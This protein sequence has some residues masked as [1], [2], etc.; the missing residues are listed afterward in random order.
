LSEI[1]PRV[2]ERIRLPLWGQVVKVEGSVP[3]ALVDGLGDPVEPVQV[4][5]RDFTARGKSPGSVRSYAMDLL[6]WWRFLIAIGVAWDQVSS[7]DVRDFVLWLT[8]AT[9]SLAAQR[10]QSARTVGTINPITRK[11][12]LDDHYKPATIRHSNAVLRAFY[13]FWIERGEGPMFNPVVRELGRNGAR[14]NAHHNP[15]QPFRAEGRL[16]YNPRLPKRRPRMMPDEEWGRFF[17]V[18]ASNRDR[19]LMAVD[20]SA[21]ARASELLGMV[22]ADID[23]GDQLIRVIRK[24]TRAEQWLPA[25]PEAF[26]W[27]RLYFNDIGPVGANDVVWQTLHRRDGRRQPLNYDALR[28]VLRRANVKLGTNWT[29]HDLRHT[30][31]KRM[32]RDGRLSLADVQA[33]LG[34]AH[35]STTQIYLEEDDAAVFARVREHLAERERSENVPPPPVAAGYDPAELDIL[36][37]GN[38]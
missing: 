36:F 17:A 3:W 24:G 16:R 33:I 22:G 27:L 29:M 11:R 35:L 30:A 13:D 38:A 34:H 32:I 2:V 8:Q 18:M 14:A 28:A 1:N 19:A 10:K 25:S 31:A 7:A 26:V 9:K 20:V 5:L 4:F 15:L 37:G 23:W 21:A 12:Y 6:R